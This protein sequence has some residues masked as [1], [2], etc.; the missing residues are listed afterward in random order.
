[1][2][3]GIKVINDFG[4]VLIDDVSPAVSLK[5][6]SNVTV[7]NL[8][9]PRIDVANSESVVLA[10]VSAIWWK[11]S[12]ADWSG[13]TKR[14]HHNVVYGTFGSNNLTGYAFDKP[15]DL[16]GSNVG[17]KIRDASGKVTF[18]AMQKYA[19][20]VADMTANGTFTGTS[21]RT[22]AGIMLSQYYKDEIALDPGVP[23]NRQ[24]NVWG[25]FLRSVGNTLQMSTQLI[26]QI[27]YPSGDSPSVIAE[28][29]SPRALV[30]D[31]TGY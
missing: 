29:G 9:V 16:V 25:T 26:S 27:I 24:R 15:S 6:K 10:V 14:F 21:G 8:T 7:N 17:L 11:P 1:M 31:V 3:T 22:Y 5:Q 2:A 30:L 18:D 4:T 23:S 20:V 19:R 13:T 28:R 12:Y